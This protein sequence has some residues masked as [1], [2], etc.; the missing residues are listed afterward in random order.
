M[1][2]ELLATLFAGFAGAGVALALNLITGG[3]LP[4][5]T[6]PV[7][8]AGAML[9]ATITSEMTWFERSQ[10]QLPE[11]VVVIRTNETTAFYRPWTYL[12]PMI[13]RFAA[14][15][16]GGAQTNPDVPQQRIVDIYLLERWQAA[17]A[18]QLGV[19]CQTSAQVLMEAARFGESGAIEA[20]V[21]ESLGA[22]DPL[23]AALC[24][25]A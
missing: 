25:P 17:R 4:K 24:A 16:I 3:R 18:V 20:D 14:A 19:D 21:W 22:D 7:L 9:L 11:S 23:I 15:D 8:A 13:N 10:A 6:M 5:A 12:R 2:W 1:F